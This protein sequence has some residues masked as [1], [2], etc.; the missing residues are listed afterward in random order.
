DGNLLVAGDADRIYVWDMATRKI[1]SQIELSLPNQHFIPTLAFFSDRRILVS[2]GGI[3]LR[4]L[5]SGRGVLNVPGCSGDVDALAGFPGADRVA[6]ISRTSVLIP[7]SRNPV[8][9]YTLRVWETNSWNEVLTLPV[10][11]LR[12][13]EH[14]GFG[15]VEPPSN[16]LVRADGGQIVVGVPEGRQIV[17]GGDGRPIAVGVT[18]RLRIW[19]AAGAPDARRV[20]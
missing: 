3:S 16:I 11:S 10:E 18:G 1:V 20:K 2:E 19:E 6:A 14:G 17:A 8:S 5:P 13:G 7:Q 9:Q 12:R 4:G 15:Y